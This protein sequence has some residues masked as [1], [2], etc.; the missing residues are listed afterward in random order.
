MA[1][2]AALVYGV[3]AYA[4]FFGSFLYAIGFTGN[5]VVPRSVDVGPD[6]PALQALVV[7]TLLLGLFAV[8]HS[9]MARPAFKAWWTRFVPRPVERSTYVLISSLLLI[10]LFWQWR[11]LP[12]VIW[13]VDYPAGQALL[14]GLFG[15]GW[16]TVLLSTFMLSHL[17]LF[18][19]Q[20]VCRHFARKAEAQHE[21]RTPGFYRYVRH[22]I[23]LGF[24]VAFWATPRMTA[25]HLL[26]AAATAGYIV[27]GV[28]LEERDLV[29]YF[30]ER[31]REY[32]RR[33]PMLLPLPGK[34]RK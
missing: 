34:R 3:L 30:G 33:V 19:L 12:A 8:Q 27:I 18:G 7:D 26:F 21:F 29:T 16:L 22:P 4:V 5:L 6:A 2:V 31:Y 28:L 17:E 25:G 15:A 24:L 23:M 1:P 11:P 10:L 9:G 14:W 32:Q 13:S 20:Q